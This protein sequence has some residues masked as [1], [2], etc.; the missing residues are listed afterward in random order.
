[1][2][3][4]QSNDDT[5]PI[6]VYARRRHERIATA[7]DLSKTLNEDTVTHILSYLSKLCAFP[8]RVYSLSGAS[9]VTLEFQC[10]L[11]VENSTYDH[12]SIEV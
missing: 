2:A 6:K 1:M 9:N 11:G 4:L 7:T 10:W 12:A 5:P 8:G 3:S